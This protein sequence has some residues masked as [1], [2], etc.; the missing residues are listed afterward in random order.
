MAKL[1]AKNYILYRSIQYRPGDELPRSDAEMEAL[2]LECGTAYIADGEEKE[3][4]KAT[5]VSALAGS[6]GLATPKSAEDTDLIGRV[7]K[8]Q[9]KAT[10]Q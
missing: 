5:P 6:E 2:W 4:A 3:A 1:I 7:P 9:R 10:K 8:R